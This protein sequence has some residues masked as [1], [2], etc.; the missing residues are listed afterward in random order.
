MC[1]S[2]FVLL[3]VALDKAASINTVV[4]KRDITAFCIL[5]LKKK[6]KKVINLSTST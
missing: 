1:F 6:K 2:F 4:K 3:R 5:A